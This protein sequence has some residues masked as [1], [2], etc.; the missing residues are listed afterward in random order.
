MRGNLM[1][2]ALVR[3]MAAACGFVALRVAAGAGNVVIDTTYEA[4]HFYATPTLANGKKL[5]LLLDTGGG[6][7][8]TNWIN[9]IQAKS[10]G[11]APS[12]HCK[13]NGQYFNLAQPKYRGAG[14]PDLGGDCAGLVITDDG[15]ATSTDGQLVPQ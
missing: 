5:R 15:G 1:K 8:P 11:L 7:R 12:A 9:E 4:G 2:L 10:G 13:W 6:T 3:V 14:L